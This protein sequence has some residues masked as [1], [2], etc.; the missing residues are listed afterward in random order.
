[1]KDIERA[2]EKEK[3]Y[4]YYRMQNQEPFH[5]VDAIRE[6]GF[7]SLDEYFEAK[8]ANE[9]HSISFEVIDASSPKASVESIFKVITEKKNA[10]IFVNI[11]NTMVW[12]QINS[13]CNVEYCTA[14]NIPI[15]PVGANGTGTLVS[16]PGD[17][18]IGICVYKDSGVTMKFLVDGFVEIFR[19][20]TDKE[21]INQGNDIM[22]DGK[23]I[24]GFTG[25]DMNEM[26]MIISPISFSEKADLVINIC[27]NKPQKKQVGYIDFMNR[28]DLRQEVS[29]WLQVHS[30]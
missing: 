7:E 12:T 3:E 19:K 9:F 29:A 2:I 8:I 18:G 23:K 26:F 22:Y 15:V 4:L 5:L 20:Y 6:L 17:F 30:I 21:I 13:G 11:D 16:T 25:Y 14:N 27:T 28:D 24:C 10:V 1:M